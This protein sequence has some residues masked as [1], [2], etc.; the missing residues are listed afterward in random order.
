TVPAC[1]SQSSVVQ[2]LQKLSH[3]ASTREPTATCLHVGAVAR[4]NSPELDVHAKTHHQQGVERRNLSH[5]P[6]REHGRVCRAF[7]GEESMC[8]ATRSIGRDPAQH[9]R[10]GPLWFQLATPLAKVRRGGRRMPTRTPG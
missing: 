9:S 5:H 1:L 2:K 3:Q 7:E 10:R 4:K 8:R 6:R